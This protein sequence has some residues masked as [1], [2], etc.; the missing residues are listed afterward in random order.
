MANMVDKVVGENMRIWFA[1]RESA[2]GAEFFD[3]DTVALSEEASAARV[4]RQR[5]ERS[6]TFIE[7]AFPITR[8]QEVELVE[9]RRAR[10]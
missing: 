8:Y 5:K 1:V 9:F 4:I 7:R 6:S 10:K 2:D 3:F